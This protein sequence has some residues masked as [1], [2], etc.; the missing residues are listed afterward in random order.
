MPFLYIKFLINPLQP[1][2][3]KHT[4]DIF[5]NAMKLDPQDNVRDC[6][7]LYGPR[8]SAI[9]TMCFGLLIEHGSIV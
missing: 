8:R 4:E 2:Q 5:H 3:S 7:V 6:F 9:D 1:D